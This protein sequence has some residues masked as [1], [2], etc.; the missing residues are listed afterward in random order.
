MKRTF[1]A[2]GLALSLGLSAPML[3]QAKTPPEVL[4]PYKAYRAALKVNDAKA[5][6]K[7]AYDAWQS[8]ETHLGDHKTTGDL[9]LNYADIKSDDQS[10]T[11]V[12]AIERA[13]ELTSFYG[14]DAPSI[15]M[16]RGI[17]HLH[18]LTIRGET[19]KERKAA[20]KLIEYARENGQARSVFFAEALTIKAGASAGNRNGKKLLKLTE[21]ALDVFENPDEIY[22]S[23]Y[24]IFAHLYNGFGH[25]YEDD[26]LE[27]ALSYQKVMDYVG[28]LEYGTHP[29]VGR[30]LGRWSHMRSRLLTEGDADSLK[31]MGVCECWPYDVERNETV[32][33]VKRVPPKFSREALSSSVSGYTIVQFDLDDE[34]NTINPEVIV[35]WPADM[36]EKSSLKSLSQWEYTPRVA[37]ETDVDRTN[38]ISTI[39][40]NIQD[41][42]GNPVY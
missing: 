9:A 12:K 33:P 24:P 2:V 28:K 35:S 11:Q 36:Y 5:A 4:E 27:A 10:K 19:G 21:E 14:E 34:G 41:R 39:R 40:Y 42:F 6:I 38:L 37:D 13:M 25:E 29:I 1:L 23:A 26:I 7:H 16:Q 18:L 20:D 31:E 8:A 15:Y 30:A 22:A 3:A 32:K 17:S